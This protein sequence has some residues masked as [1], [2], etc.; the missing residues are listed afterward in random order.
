MLLGLGHLSAAPV[1]GISAADEANT[2]VWLGLS[3]FL[4]GTTIAAI[5]DQKTFI[6]SENCPQ[7]TDDQKIWELK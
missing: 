3:E 1:V 7:K 4:V 5:S 6:T 2:L